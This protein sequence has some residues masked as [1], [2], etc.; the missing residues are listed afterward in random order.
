MERNRASAV[1]NLRGIIQAL[2]EE[3]LESGVIKKINESIEQF[4]DYDIGP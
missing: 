4:T 1:S 2:E 3:K